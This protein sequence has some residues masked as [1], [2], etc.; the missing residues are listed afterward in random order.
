[1]VDTTPYRT[2]SVLVRDQVTRELKKADPRGFAA[3]QSLPT[4]MDGWAM[5]AKEKHGPDR[6]M[7]A[8]VNVTDGCPVGGNSFCGHYCFA[9]RS[10]NGTGVRV[11][12]PQ[13][14]ARD[15]QRLRQEGLGVSIFLSTDT[16]PVPGKGQISEVTL[17]LLKTMVEHPPDG[18]LVHSH[19]DVLGNLEFLAVLKALSQATNLLAG[20]GFDTDSDMVPDHLCGHFSSVRQRL[21]AFERMA[22]S[23]IHTQASVT[24]LVGFVDFEGFGRLFHELGAYR[25]MVGELRTKF[26][27]GGSENAVGLDID[28]GLP[29]PTE[30][31]ALSFFRG[32]GFK[33]GVDLRETFYVLLP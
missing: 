4:F 23:G 16:E 31:H 27:K 28:L 9:H 2:A 15:M 20:I 8:T 22:N 7:I 14:Y 1:M 18:I 33:G 25:V 3:I 5:R 21:L 10:W 17:E 11:D 6:L 32:L 13:K 26:P 24:P 29:T 30:E 19:T 12:T